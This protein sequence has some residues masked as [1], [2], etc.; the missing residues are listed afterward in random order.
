MADRKSGLIALTD[1]EVTEQAQGL[2]T[3]RTGF[4]ADLALAFMKYEAAGHSL[5]L[6]DL[7]R[8]IVSNQPYSD[9]A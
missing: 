6:P 4:A 7:A 1:Q 5:P 3:E 9:Q 8:C 2:I